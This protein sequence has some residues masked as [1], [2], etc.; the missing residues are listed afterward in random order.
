MEQ[1]LRSSSRTGIHAKAVVKG[2]VT[3]L[4]KASQSS[5]TVVPD[6]VPRLIEFEGLTR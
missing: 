1:S 4:L 5:R 2:V 3:T 6:P